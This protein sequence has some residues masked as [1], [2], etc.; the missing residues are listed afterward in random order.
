[1]FLPTRM[2]P[3]DRILERGRAQNLWKREDNTVENT[4]GRTRCV[5]R[6]IKRR[7]Q[8]LGMGLLKESPVSYAGEHRP[9]LTT[10][11]TRALSQSS[12][13]AEAAIAST[14]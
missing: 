14:T 13:S 8:L 11:I 2:Q 6:H 9:T 5:R 3:A 1:M 4:D 10:Q 12:F 7:G